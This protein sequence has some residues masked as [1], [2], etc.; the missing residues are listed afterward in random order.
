MIAPS[1]AR[2]D[3]EPFPL[4]AVRPPADPD[5]VHAR[6]CLPDC[7]SD[8]GAI[9]SQSLG[10]YCTHNQALIASFLFLVRQ[11]GRVEYE[12]QLW[13]GH[14]E[15]ETIKINVRRAVTTLTPLQ[16]L[17]VFRYITGLQF[18]PSDAKIT[19]SLFRD[20][21]PSIASRFMLIIYLS[22]FVIRDTLSVQPMV[23]ACL[24]SVDI[25]PSM[26]WDDCKL[27]DPFFPAFEGNVSH[28]LHI[29]AA[30][31][32][33]ERALIDADQFGAILLNMI[34]P[35]YQDAVPDRIRLAP[36]IKPRTTVPRMD[37]NFTAI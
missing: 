8:Q 12:F 7:P 4:L 31:L 18:V 15:S 6:V 22:Q 24:S 17:A 32:S 10:A 30:D 27:H 19:V 35:G 16:A 28:I 23:H 26:I 2:T 14:F 9:R 21:F 20:D 11:P 37:T 1:S 29:F 13:P 36:K 5:K 34:L 25:S 33:D 3:F